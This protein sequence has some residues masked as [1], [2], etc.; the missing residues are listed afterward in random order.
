[1]NHKKQAE[2]DPKYLELLLEPLRACAQYTPNFGKND[3]QEFTIDQFHEVYGADPLYHW[4][5]FDSELMYAAHKAAGGMTSVYRQLGTGCERLFRASIGDSLKLQEEDLDWGYDV[6][7]T[8]GSIRRL[9][10]DA[11]IEIDK[12]SGLRATQRVSR[13]L[14]TAAKSLSISEKR[15]K[16][17]FGAVFEVRQGYK[18]ADAKRQNADLRNASHAFSENYLP[19]IAVLSTQISDTLLRRYRNGQMLVLTGDRSGDVLRDTYEFM[20][21]IVGYSLDGFFE[22][23]SKALRSEVHKILSALLS[24]K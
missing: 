16:Q 6:E 8:D 20:N 1:M 22:R 18:S 17:L 24:P 14:A 3:R 9:S 10:L 19:V 21:K 15:S 4:M 5:G 12:L 13:W 11:R 7:R 23:N 2:R